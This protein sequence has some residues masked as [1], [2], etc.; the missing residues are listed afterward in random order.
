MQRMMRG[1][2]Q[3]KFMRRMEAM[4]GKARIEF[5]PVD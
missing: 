2:N 5:L 3:K 4:K 1:G